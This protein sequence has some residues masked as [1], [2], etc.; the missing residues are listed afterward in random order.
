VRATGLSSCVREHA[1]VTVAC[2]QDNNKQIGTHARPHRD[3][4][5]EEA[6]RRIG[7]AFKLT[8][9]RSEPALLSAERP[10]PGAC[11]D[12]SPPSSPHIQ[13]GA[14]FLHTS[15]KQGQVHRSRSGEGPLHC[16]WLGESLRRQQAS[17]TAF[18]ARLHASAGSPRCLLSCGYVEKC[19]RAHLTEWALQ[20]QLRGDKQS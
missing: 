17:A 4:Y 1:S 7:F 19:Y 3:I 20:R 2:F 5:E 11:T 18:D 6:P 12:A 8:S 10:S 15:R 13:V 16:A 9:M 14:R